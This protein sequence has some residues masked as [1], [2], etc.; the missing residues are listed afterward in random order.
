MATI[1]LLP[2]RDAQRKRRNRN[3]LI[4]LSVSLILGIVATFLAW[5][6]VDQTLESQYAANDRISAKNNALSAELIL[7]KNLMRRRDD[8]MAQTEAIHTLQAQSSMPVR[9]WDDVAKAIPDTLYLSGMAGEQAL[10]TLIGRADNPDRVARLIEGLDASDWLN[11]ATVKFVK[12]NTANIASISS[13]ESF[14][15]LNNGQYP[16][17][18]YIDFVVTTQMQQ[19]SLSNPKQPNTPLNGDGV[20]P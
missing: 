14:N 20:E 16:E 19:A 10:L 4:V 12:Q 2:W 8:I 17:D 5:C 15:S 9:V 3:F 7:I 11:E 6:Y 18:G 1:N 13:Q